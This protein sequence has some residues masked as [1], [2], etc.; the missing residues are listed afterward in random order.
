MIRSYV[1]NK[2]AIADEHRHP[3]PQHAIATSFV[4]VPV[5]YFVKA[6]QYVISK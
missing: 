2:T 6:L 1:K 3:F 4:L 5:Q